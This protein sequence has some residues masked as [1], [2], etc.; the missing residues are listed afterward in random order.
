MRL[1]LLARRFS[2]LINRLPFVNRFRLR[3][4]KLQFSSTVLIGCKIKV[5]GTDNKIFFNG[6]GGFKNTTITIIGNHNVIEF[7]EGV[8][9]V[10]GDILLEGNNSLF[11]VGNN[12]KFCGKIH[13]A[14]IESTSCYIGRDCLFSSN[15]TIR[16]GDS[17]SIVN[18]IGDRINPSNDVIIDEHCWV[19]NSVII[20]KGVVVGKNCIIGTGSVVIKS[21]SLIE[22]NVIIAGSPARIVKKD[23]NWA[24]ERLPINIEGD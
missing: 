15:I 5:N 18:L 19:C 17:H 6:N 10:S 4:T 13:I 9:M 21:K 12:T 3:K 8:S 2:W 24:T 11:I 16:T 14:M 7:A 23:I 20:T 22:D 1:K